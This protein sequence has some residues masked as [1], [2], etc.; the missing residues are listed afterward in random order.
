M[1]TLQWVTD[2]PTYSILLY[3]YIGEGEGVGGDGFTSQYI[4]GKRFHRSPNSTLRPNFSTEDADQST[5]SYDWTVLPIERISS[6][7]AYEY[8]SN[9]TFHLDI[10]LASNVENG[11]NSQ[12]FQIVP[13]NS[14]SPYS[15]Y[16][17]D[18][19]YSTTDGGYG[20]GYGSP[21]TVTQS[22][23]YPYT[24]TAD[25]A[26]SSA[27]PTVTGDSTPIT[28]FEFSPFPT[29]KTATVFTTLTSSSQSSGVTPTGSVRSTTS[30]PT[31]SA[32]ASAFTGAAG[33]LQN[34]LGIGL[35]IGAILAAFAA[36]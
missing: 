33:N 7:N 31:T 4:V 34:G 19:P 28:T 15:S 21:A 6:T 8:G 30:T 12:D 18:D 25:S 16:S 20:Y 10:V 14:S 32:S 17:T 24:V 13:S 27:L 2:Y 22:V 9:A 1:V 11:M 35:S 29:T 23:F 3:Q 36:V 26:S 5:D